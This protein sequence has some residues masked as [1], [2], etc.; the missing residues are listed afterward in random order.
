[1][2]A[3]DE[4][5]KDVYL[6]FRG[7]EG[8]ATERAVLIGEPNA[9][10]RE[11]DAEHSWHLAFT[12]R[13]LWDLRDQLGLDFPEDF[14]IE[15]AIQYAVDHDVIEVWAGDVNAMTNDTNQVELKA[16][17]EEGAYQYVRR[18]HPKLAGMAERWKDY[19][20]KD[21]PEA[22]YISD[23][24]KVIAT[25]TI[26]LDGGRKWHDWEGEITTRNQMLRIVRGKLLSEFGHSLFDVIEDDVAQNPGVFPADEGDSSVD[27]QL[28][29]F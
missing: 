23:L 17:R 4:I 28:R 19:E 9:V 16:E 13:V 7:A 5:I 27:I 24:D 12:A 25:R 1:M 18:W 26:Y 3:I 22:Q 8:F 6:P 29:F 21:S 14:Q 2:G 10:H 15:K 20:T 11:N